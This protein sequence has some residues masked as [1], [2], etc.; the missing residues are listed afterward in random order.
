V[1]GYLRNLCE[2]IGHAEPE[3]L[4]ELLYVVTIGGTYLVP[5][6]PPVRKR[7]LF[8]SLLPLIDQPDPLTAHT[9]SSDLSTGD[10]DHE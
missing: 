2:Q 9:E 10:M 7:A 4:A 3:L 5:P 6:L 8:E 1:Y